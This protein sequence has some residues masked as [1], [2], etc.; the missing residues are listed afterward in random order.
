MSGAAMVIVYNP[1]IQ[2]LAKQFRS[3]FTGAPAVFDG[4]HQASRQE[5][6]KN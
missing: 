2:N 3:P 4:V 6:G 1:L 5:F